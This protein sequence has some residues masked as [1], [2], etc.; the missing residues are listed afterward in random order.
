MKKTAVIIKGNPKLVEGNERANAFY[1]SL[2]VFLESLDFEVSFDSGE[3]YTQPPHAD[4]WIGHSR[5][6]DRLRFA[7]PEVI[8][9]GLGVPESRGSTDFP[10]V[11][12]P[13]DEMAKLV[14]QD[15]KIIKEEAVQMFDDSYHYILTEEMKEE[16]KNIIENYKK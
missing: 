16:I 11:N 1:E 2:K 14:F 3:P 12:H 10:V 5:G 15:G 9:I 8:T 13:K 6:S 4:V 7:L